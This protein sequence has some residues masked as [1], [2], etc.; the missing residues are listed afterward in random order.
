MRINPIFCTPLKPAN[1]SNPSFK[2]ERLVFKIFKGKD[3]VPTDEKPTSRLTN[4]EA[5]TVIFIVEPEKGGRLNCL[6]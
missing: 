5:K 3:M 2:G 6:V 4:K 1:K